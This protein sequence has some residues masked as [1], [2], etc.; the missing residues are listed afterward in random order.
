MAAK[1]FNRIAN[2]FLNT[3]RIATTID[4][5]YV[6]FHGA[7]SAENE[8]DPEGYLLY[9]MRQI[10]G[11]SIPIVISL[12]LHGILTDRMLK[13]CTAFTV[14]HT[15]PHV[16]FYDTGVRAAKLLLKILEE[17][18][19]PIIAKV[20]IPALV[21]GDELITETGLFGKFIRNVSF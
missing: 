1:D 15:Y 16:D 13:H 4:A 3:I 14:F 11:E 8:I 21:R 20:N 5:A 12:D 9:E 10:L 6:S 19:K 2:E 7:M 17:D 18:A